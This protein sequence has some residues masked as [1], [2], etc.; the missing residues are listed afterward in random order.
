[1]KGS[2]V[3]SLAKKVLNIACCMDQKQVS[4]SMGTWIRNT[5]WNNWKKAKKLT[6][7][8]GFAVEKIR[9]S[10]LFASIPLFRILIGFNA[11]PDADLYPA[12]LRSMRMP[13]RIQI[14]I[15]IQIQGF[16]DKKLEK[17]KSW[18][19]C[20]FFLKNCNLVIPRPS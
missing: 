4:K 8:S 12:F 14:L 15:L 2:F 18:K 19:N 10:Y 6:E 13:I 17:I 5:N 16:D 7:I 9:D 11:D 20:I 1:M 3:P